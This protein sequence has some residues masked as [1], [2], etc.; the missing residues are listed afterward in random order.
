MTRHRLLLPFVAAFLVSLSG[1]PTLAQAQQRPAA[2]GVPTGPGGADPAIFRSP[3]LS[4]VEFVMAY[5]RLT[6]TTIDF[7][8]FA[9]NSTAVRNA[10][11]FDRPDVLARE[12]ARLEGQFAALDLGRVYLMR[13]GTQLRQYD[14][15]RGG[16]P[17][18]LNPEAYISISDPVT[19]RP[20]GLQF[21]NVEDIAV[22]PVGDTTAARNFAQRHGL[23]TQYEIA[24]DVVLELAIRLIE[25]PPAIAS[26]ITIVRADIAAARISTR[27]NQPMWDFGLTSAGRAPAPT[28]AAPGSMPILKAAD[29]QGVRVGMPA[30]EAAGIASRAYPTERYRSDQGG[31]W[32]RNIT[33]GADRGGF[34]NTDIRCGL[35]AV[36]AYDAAMSFAQGGSLSDI[37]VADV[38]EACFGYDAAMG[39]GIV[40]RGMIA[41]ISSGQRLPGATFEVVRQALTEKYGTPT[42]TRQEGRTL[43]WIG[44]DPGRQDGSLVAITARIEARQGGGVVLGVDAAAYVDP[45]QRRAPVPASAPSAPRL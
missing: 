15:Q 23:N 22:V 21:R 38:S 3:P 33:P 28:A 30:A 37:P 26:G 5:H 42:Y 16:Y 14:G 34:N 31:R 44:R 18:S 45:I 25:A 32:Y 27:N 13:V 20:F 40:P 8:P 9:Q 10:T 2:P 11:T 4:P 6:G 29:I 24:G 12:I 7:A 19:S 43:Q 36:S 17:I 39:D 41:R 35:D 1:Y